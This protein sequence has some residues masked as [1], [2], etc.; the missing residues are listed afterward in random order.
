MPPTLEVSQQ[1]QIITE[2]KSIGETA[3][4][5]GQLI[6]VQV[7]TTT[8]AELTEGSDTNENAKPGEIVLQDCTE[9]YQVLELDRQKRCSNHAGN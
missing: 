4:F 9:Q 3:I 6:P 2:V 7:V 8:T 1:Q 5:E